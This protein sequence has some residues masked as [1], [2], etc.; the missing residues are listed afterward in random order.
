VDLRETLRA[1]IDA[2]CS[3][4]SA[5]STAGVSRHTVESRVH[6]AEQLIGRAIRTCIPELDVA[7]RFEELADHRARSI[8]R[9][10]R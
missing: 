7:L 1:Y 4:T 6:K 2:G 9:S 3:A 8:V 5:T 10:A